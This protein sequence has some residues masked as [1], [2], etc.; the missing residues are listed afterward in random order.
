VICPLK[1]AFRSS[2][3]EEEVGLGEVAVLGMLGCVAFGRRRGRVRYKS[4]SKKNKY[5]VVNDRILD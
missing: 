4:R 5:V 3:D 2:V 1:A